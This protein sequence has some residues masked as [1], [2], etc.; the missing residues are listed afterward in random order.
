MSLLTGLGLQEDKELAEARRA[1]TLGD[2]HRAWEL[3]ESQSNE[4]MRLRG[5][6]EILYKAGD[7]SGAL[8]AAKAGLEMSPTQID[9]IY[10]AACAAIWLEEGSEGIRHSTRLIHV[11]GDMGESTGRGWRQAGEELAI[12][13]RTIADRSE[14]LDRSVG[15][16][17]LVAIGGIAL[18][19]SAIWSALRLQGRSSKPVS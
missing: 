17:R 14:Q 1:L 2:Y 9:M 19:L 3:V 5:R 12:R 16:L 11:A 18:W 10:H 4:L 7:P 8:R 6:T 13:A 15:R